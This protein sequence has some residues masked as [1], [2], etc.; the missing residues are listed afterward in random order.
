[1]REAEE[2]ETPLSVGGHDREEDWEGSVLGSVYRAVPAL[3]VVSS[4]DTE[5]MLRDPVE[6]RRSSV[7]AAYL[8]SDSFGGLGRSSRSLLAC[9]RTVRR[10]VSG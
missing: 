5:L 2:E 3:S 1:M 4:F 6:A 7:E 10:G 8:V 9:L